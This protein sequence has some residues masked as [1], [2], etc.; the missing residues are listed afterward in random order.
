MLSV[1]KEGVRDVV[2]QWN[3]GGTQQ[4]KNEWE[5]SFPG[6]NCFSGYLKGCFPRCQN[7]RNIFYLVRTKVPRMYKEGCLNFLGHRALGNSDGYH[8]PSLQKIHGNACI[9][10]HT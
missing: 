4:K 9:P 2:S 10:F 7:V 5:S 1:S 8:G 3:R 6:L